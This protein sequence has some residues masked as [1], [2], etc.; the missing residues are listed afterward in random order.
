MKLDPVKKNESFRFNFSCNIIDNETLTK[1]NNNERAKC[2]YCLFCNK[3]ILITV[4]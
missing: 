1:H 2:M 3:L 4:S